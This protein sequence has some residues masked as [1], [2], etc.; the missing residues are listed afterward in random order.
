L[1]SRA[2]LAASASACAI[3][4]ARR[5]SSIAAPGSRSSSATSSSS[6]VRAAMS[7]GPG[8]LAFAA[9]LDGNGERHEGGLSYRR[10]R[11]RDSAPCIRRATTSSVTSLLENEFALFHPTQR[12]RPL[13]LLQHERLICAPRDDR[14]H[15][16]GREQRQPQDPASVIGPRVS[17]PSVIGP[18]VS[19]PHRLRRVAELVLLSVVDARP[20]HDAVRWS[21]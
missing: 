19:I 10:L 8:D 5:G 2:G 7:Q 9:L 18:R 15:D 16:F 3:S 13:Q 4:A 20:P 6:S 17:I 21:G 1:G 14:L 11:S 12:E